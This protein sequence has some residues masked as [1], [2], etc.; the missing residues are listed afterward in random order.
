MKGASILAGI[1]CLGHIGFSSGAA[2]PLED[3]GN[4]TY[5]ANTGL[6]W[7]DLSLT[8]G[9]SYHEVLTGS[10]GF[11]TEQGYRFASGEEIATLFLHAGQSFTDSK[12]NLLAAN[13]AL[14]LLGT[15]L[16]EP[17]QRRSWM[18]YDPAS[19][20]T[21]GSAHAP[22]A[23]FG[24]GE[25]GGGTIG[26]QGFFLVPGIIP[27]REYAS[28]EIGSALVRAVPEPRGWVLFLSGTL[29]LVHFGRT[30]R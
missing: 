17:A 26:E 29:L 12:A 19:D 28:P 13:Q 18:L 8:A 21:I 24:V 25:I 15:T 22:A 30:R 3:R 9:K 23:V 4:T 14:L 16:V 27:M 2:V 20:S 7:L 11:T 1:F 5:D 10:G 6:E